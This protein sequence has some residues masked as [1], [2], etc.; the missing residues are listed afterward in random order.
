[1]VKGRNQTDWLIYVSFDERGSLFDLD[2]FR[3]LAPALA[4]C[5]LLILFSGVF[6]LCLSGKFRV[7]VMTLGFR[8][9]IFPEERQG[10]AFSKRLRRLGMLDAFTQTDEG[11]VER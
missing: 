11:G 2:K 5:G 7:S 3:E 10:A 8:R 6:E 9:R 4:I 1:M